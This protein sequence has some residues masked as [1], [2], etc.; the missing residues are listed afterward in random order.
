[1]HTYIVTPVEGDDYEVEADDID[2][3]GEVVAFTKYVPPE[4]DEKYGSTV[5]LS[6]I[7]ARL[8]TYIYMK[9]E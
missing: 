6:V 1:M 9:G 5:T 4:G 2:Y 3:G 8:L 7:P